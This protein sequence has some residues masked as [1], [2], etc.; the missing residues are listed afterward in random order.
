MYCTRTY[1]VSFSNFRTEF[2]SESLKHAFA[3]NGNPDVRQRRIREGARRAVLQ[4][5]ER[6]G[7]D[8]PPLFFVTL[9]EGLRRS[10]WPAQKMV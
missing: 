3:G 6:Y 1:R 9:S 10:S 8:V 2:Q 7:I 5:P 4:N